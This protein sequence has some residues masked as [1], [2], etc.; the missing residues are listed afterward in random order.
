M[1]YDKE[2]SG[3]RKFWVVWLED[4][5]VGESK[6]AD[7][8]DRSKIAISISNNFHKT[9]RALFQTKVDPKDPFKLIVTRLK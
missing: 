3:G 4:F 2:I 8:K 5:A 6:P 1:Y 9:K 7:I